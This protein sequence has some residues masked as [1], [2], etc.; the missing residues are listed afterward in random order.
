M[1]QMQNQSFGLLHPRK[2]CRDVTENDRLFTMA[3]LN[4][5]SL[6]LRDDNKNFI[7]K[8][9]HDI[10]FKTAAI[11]L[12]DERIENNSKVHRRDEDRLLFFDL[13]REYSI[14]FIL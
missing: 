14:L 2:P 7:N 13:F 1:I 5:V 3:L 6:V 4:S 9:K 10:D 12:D 11:V 8:R